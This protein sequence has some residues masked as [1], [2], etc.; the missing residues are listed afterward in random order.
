MSQGHKKIAVVSDR[1]PVADFF[2]LEAKAC[3]CDVTVLGE[4][5]T[6]TSDYDVIISDDAGEIKHTSADCRIIMLVHEDS[7]LRKDGEIW[8]YPVPLATVRELFE[9]YSAV[10][11]VDKEETELCFIHGK[12]KSLL[13][14]NRKIKLTD[15]EWQVF[16]RLAENKGRSVPRSELMELFGADGGNISDVYIYHLRKKL[17]EPFGRRVISTV[18]NKG[19]MLSEDINIVDV[20]Y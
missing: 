3:G 4:L 16:L 5:P 20:A 11:S 9:G 13:Y 6:D 2:A 15:G 12:E 1:P 17:E 7:D 14:K 8:E 18:R 10:S 19:Y